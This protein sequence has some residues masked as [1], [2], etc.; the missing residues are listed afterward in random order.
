M[1]EFDLGEKN[2]REGIQDK[3]RALFDS[4]IGREVLRDIL[5]NCEFG[6]ILHPE[7]YIKFMWHNIAVTILK[8]CGMIGPDLMDQVVNGF[9][10]V[11]PTKQKEVER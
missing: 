4:P 10:N 11:I 6:S 2:P 8:E 3:Y 9:C 1:A 5:Q 7:N